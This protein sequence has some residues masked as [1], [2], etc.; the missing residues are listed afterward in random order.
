MKAGKTEIFVVL[1]NSY[2]LVEGTGYFQGAS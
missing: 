1:F 2:I